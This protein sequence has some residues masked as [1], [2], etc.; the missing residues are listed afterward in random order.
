M[1]TKKVWRRAAAILLSLLVC[2][3]SLECTAFA[4]AGIDPARTA[5]LRVY[6]GEGTQVFAEVPFSI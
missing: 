1:K 4:A 2:M 3:L 6:F 5:S